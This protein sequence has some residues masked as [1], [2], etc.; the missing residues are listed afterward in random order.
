[1]KISRRLFFCVTVLAST[2]VFSVE[3]QL[4]QERIDSAATML[5]TLVETYGVSGDEDRVRSAVER[6][7]PDWA[8]PSVDSAGNLWVR[9]G[10][11]DPVVVFVAHIDEVGWEVTEIRSDGKL[12]MRQLG[13]FMPWL[14]E[15]SPALVHTRSGQIPG[16]FTP[17]DGAVQNRQ[18]SDGFVV[19]VGTSSAAQTAALD[20]AVGD[21][22]TNPKR[23]VR[24]AGNRATGRSFD[25]RVGSVAQVMALHSINPEELD[26]EIIFLWV[27]EEEIG[28]IGSRVAAGALGFQ[29]VRVYAVDTF[30]SADSPHDAQKL[31]GHDR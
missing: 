2:Q 31:R 8:D 13:G 5:G 17:R 24:L 1:M 3:A 25:D 21:N 27:V 30:V 18:A 14:W 4:R 26:H 6:L 29:P 19:D 15:A 9:V 23:F 10:R 16:V 28:L 7:L 20:I 22:I 12:A 11:G